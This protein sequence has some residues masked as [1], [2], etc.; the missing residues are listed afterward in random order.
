MSMAQLGTLIVFVLL[1]LCFLVAFIANAP[2]G[3][4]DEEGFHL[5][6]EEPNPFAAKTDYELN[7]PAAGDGAIRDGDRPSATQKPAAEFPG[8]NRCSLVATDVFPRVA[9]TRPTFS[10]R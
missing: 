6:D 2:W 8:A 5:V 3:Y 7:Q 4:E 1:A 10:H 9:G